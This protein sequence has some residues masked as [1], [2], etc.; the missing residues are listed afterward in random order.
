MYFAEMFRSEWLRPSAIL[1]NLSNT[2][3]IFILNRNGS[4]G[5]KVTHLNSKQDVLASNLRV[6]R[7]YRFGHF[8][9]NV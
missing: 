3:N 8:Y 1:L 5:A 2:S 9:L 4:G 6:L 7:I